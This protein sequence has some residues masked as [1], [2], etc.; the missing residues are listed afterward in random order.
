MQK[1]RLIV[2][3][4]K[5]LENF[6]SL[7]DSLESVLEIPEERIGVAALFSTSPNDSFRLG[8]PFD[9][10]NNPST[11]GGKRKSH[12]AISTLIQELLK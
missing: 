7:P 3:F 12:E 4:G 5:I 11:R 6:G 10:L 1:V 2:F 8:V 9:G